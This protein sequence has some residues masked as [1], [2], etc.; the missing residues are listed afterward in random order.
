MFSNRQSDIISMRRIDVRVFL[1]YAV[2]REQSGLRRICGYGVS[3]TRGAASAMMFTYSS[4]LVTMCRNL[5]T[6]LRETF[7]NRYV[8]FDGAV[9]MHKYIAFLSAVFTRKFYVRRTATSYTTS[10][11]E[12]SCSLIFRQICDYRKNSQ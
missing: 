12:R 8:P 2:E 11:A 1:D 3:I 6:Y 4:L 5:I 9:D 10:L 7:L